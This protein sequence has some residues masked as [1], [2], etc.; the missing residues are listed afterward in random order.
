MQ[1]VTFEK[2]TSQ[3]QLLDLLHDRTATSPEAEPPSALAVVKILQVWW[4]S[5]H[6]GLDAGGTQ[7]NLLID[8]LTAM[9]VMLHDSSPAMLQIFRC[10]LAM[11]CIS[12][13][14]A[15]ICISK[16]AFSLLAI[17][18]KPSM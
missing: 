3:L 7:C 6:D 13:C 18:L 10:I 15:K 11:V 17:C 4:K 8:D 16:N 14:T 5:I 9:A 12:H 2:T 1:G